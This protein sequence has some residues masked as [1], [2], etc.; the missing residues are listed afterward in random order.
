MTDTGL[1]I[2][3]GTPELITYDFRSSTLQEIPLG[4]VALRSKRQESFR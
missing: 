1:G 3:P 4:V 2:V